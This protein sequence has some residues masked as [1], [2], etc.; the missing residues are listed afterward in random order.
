MS[1]HTNAPIANEP[2]KESDDSA[3]TRARTHAAAPRCAAT[4]TVETT[5]SQPVPV[6][7][8][9]TARRPKLRTHAKARQPAAKRA[10]ATAVKTS[11]DHR[12]RRAGRIAA[13]IRPPSPRLPTR[14]P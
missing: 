3:S 2:K 13:P 7:T 10:D 5:T 12:C 9:I 14:T 6:T 4:R 1:P 11:L 8:M